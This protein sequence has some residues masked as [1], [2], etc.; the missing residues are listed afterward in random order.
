MVRLVLRDREYEVQGGITLHQALKRL[1]IPSQTVMA[2][3]EDELI[4]E[5]ERLKDGERV[6]LI[7][8]ISGG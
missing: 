5:D 8:V 2:V 3:R 6:V 7:P 4:T 1:R